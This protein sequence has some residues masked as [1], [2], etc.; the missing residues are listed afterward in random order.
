MQRDRALPRR[1]A[2]QSSL[3]ATTRSAP[4]RSAA[5][6]SGSDGDANESIKIA[7]YSFST[8]SLGESLKH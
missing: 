4:V 8:Y 3:V 1:A 2:R 6:I 5:Q 7:K